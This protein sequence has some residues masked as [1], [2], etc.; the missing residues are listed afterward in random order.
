MACCSARP[1]RS[2][3]A[4]MRW[5]RYSGQ[6]KLAL[7]QDIREMELILNTTPDKVLGGKTPIEVYT[8]K[9]IALVA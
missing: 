2:L 3:T 8:K 7:T 6:F 1:G 4:T 9:L 5:T